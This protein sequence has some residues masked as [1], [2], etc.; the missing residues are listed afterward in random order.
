MLH[1]HLENFK[2]DFLI[3]A[4]ALKAVA[5][6]PSYQQFNLFETALRSARWKHC[7]FN[8]LL[9]APIGSA[10]RSEETHQHDAF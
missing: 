2:S 5:A 8:G 3:I 7:P 10:R 1:T 6:E 4:V 9:L